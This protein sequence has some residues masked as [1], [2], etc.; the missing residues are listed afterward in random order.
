MTTPPPPPAAAADR[1]AQPARRQEPERKPLV[2]SGPAFSIVSE[3]SRIGADGMG[4]SF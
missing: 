4:L 3:E 2:L 1:S